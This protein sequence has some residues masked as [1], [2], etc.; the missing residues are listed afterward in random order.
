MKAGDC[1]ALSR[2]AH[3]SPAVTSGLRL[4]THAHWEPLKECWKIAKESLQGKG[5]NRMEIEV[6]FKSRRL[7]KDHW[8]SRCYTHCWALAS[9]I[10][11]APGRTWLLLLTKWFKHCSLNQMIQNIFPFWVESHETHTHPKNLQ[12]LAI[13]SV[14]LSSRSFEPCGATMVGPVMLGAPTLGAT[15]LGA[16][17][18]GARLAGVNPAGAGRK[19]R[20]QRKRRRWTRTLTSTDTVP[21]LHIDELGT[22]TSFRTPL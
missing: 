10:T 3:S 18:L 4:M 13:S 8:F 16:R 14:D 7:F 12:V 9:L 20:H 21:G 11:V 1:L 19:H 5:R 22:L 6:G 2:T 15:T 17:T